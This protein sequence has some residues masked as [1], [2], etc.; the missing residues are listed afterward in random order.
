MPVAGLEPARIN[1]R[2]L[3][4]VRLPFRHT[5]APPYY[6]EN[7]LQ[8]QYLRIKK[9]PRCKK[10]VF[11]YNRGMNGKKIKYGVSCWNSMKKG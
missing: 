11:V 4:A 3:S 1:R 7:V 10:I 5:G 2:I 8:N 6:T 9:S